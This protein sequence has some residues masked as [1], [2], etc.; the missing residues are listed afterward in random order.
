VIAGIR[1]N[2]A[3][4][5]RF[6]GRVDELGALERLLDVLDAGLPGSV[7]VYG[8]PGIGKTRL[9][10]ELRARAE[11]RG[12]LV[13]YGSASELERDLP[14]S[15][16]VDALDKYLG[17]LAAEQLG[18]LDEGVQTEL[19]QVFPSLATRWV[20]RTVAVQQERYR[21]HRAVRALLEQL[22]RT[23]PVVLALDDVHWAD[24]GSVELLGALVRH[25]PASVLLALAVRPRQVPERLT[26][27]LERAHRCDELGRIVLDGLGPDEARELLH[28]TVAGAELTALHE[29]TGGNPFYMEQ[30]ARSLDWSIHPARVSDESLAR[31]GVP[32]AVA[33]SLDEELRLL[34]GRARLLLEGAAV[35][36]DPFEPELAAEAADTSESEALDAIDEL[37]ELDLLRETDVPRRF[38][39]RHPLVRR[40]VYESTPSGWRLRAHERCAQ[41]LA[42]RGASPAA[43]AHHIERSARVGDRAAVEILRT[44][45]E[46]AARLAPASAARW[47]RSALRVLPQTAPAGERVELLRARA[48]ALAATGN[49][50]ESHAALLDAMSV[51]PAEATALRAAVAAACAAVE[52]GLG[53]YEQA[54]TRLVSTLQSVPGPASVESVGLQIELIV[55]EFYRSR[56]DAMQEW[57]ERAIG[58]A[59]MTRAP[60]LIA[61]ALAT[62]ALAQASTGRIEAALASRAEAAAIVDAMSDDQLALR[63]DA[64]GWLAAAELYLDR[65]ADADTH[66]SRV[67]ALARSTGDGNPFFRLY[68]ILP[69]VW[70]MRG[71]LAEAAEFLDGAIEAV[72]LLGTPPALAG[73]LFNRSLFAVAAGDFEV[74]L[75]T[76]EEAVAV[77]RELDQGFVT[78]WAAV[79]L[80]GVLIETRQPD[81]AVELLIGRAGGED[82]PLMPG[83]WRVYSLEL[84]TRALLDC[85]RPADAERAATRA[86]AAEAALQLPMARAW[87]GRAAAA[88]ALYLGRA[89]YA[90]ERATSS[91][92]A[93]DAA[94]APIEAA[95]SRTL[96]GR[97]L[98]L[99][100]QPE[101]A[102]DELRRAA[103]SLDACGAA[104]YRERAERELG[105][106]GHRPHRRTRSGAANGLGIDGLTGREL[107]VARL[108]TDRMTNAEIAAELFLGRK[109]VETHLRNIFNKLGVA[110]RVAVA[111]AVEVAER[112]GVRPG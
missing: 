105:K 100:G 88:V 72:R 55:N 58:D 89:P 65:Y 10:T 60:G 110:D 96:L 71:K 31:I 99:A 40:T 94:G 86:E 7:V 68:Q 28:G 49:Y 13:L 111:R 106:L 102:V 3:G 37:L 11:Q 44:A 85:D 52:R 109:T 32:P 66:A 98:A 1:T 87:A 79:R 4:E 6:V 112:T 103:A 61:A 39:F 17:G 41:A 81:R 82:V 59:R 34:S 18:R 50:L 76:A 27:A 107:Q 23:R 25:P 2:Q 64:A 54:H 45:G 36:G 80:A 73:N 95:L 48:A 26:S 33:G 51:I 101:R 77:T 69:R 57:A 30:L 16:F 53:R 15:V 93:A 108:V 74:A 42:A 12:H 91:I 90:V 92:L 20:G 24:M 63:L 19:G 67:L 97:A 46:Q 75:A 38:R 104:H 62:A 35:A 43:R 83:V 5:E 78:A 84:L 8:E 70:Y 22:A 21:T 29:E 9:L 56:F 14:F 47:Y